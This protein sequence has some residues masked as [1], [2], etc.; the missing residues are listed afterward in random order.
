VPH[1]PWNHVD[2]SHKDDL[3]E[4]DTLLN[5]TCREG[6]QQLSSM[7]GFH[8]QWEGLPQ[9]RE[10]AEKERTLSSF[11]LNFDKPIAMGK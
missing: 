7:R 5:H 8:I 3:G 1:S 6:A 9:L 2:V 11:L 10:R 4:Q